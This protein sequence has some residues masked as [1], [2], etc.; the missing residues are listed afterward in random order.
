MVVL[1]IFV[2]MLYHHQPTRFSGSNPHGR[3]SDWLHDHNSSHI[4]IIPLNQIC[5]DVSDLRVS[6][7]NCV[8]HSSLEIVAQHNDCQDDDEIF[9]YD[10]IFCYFF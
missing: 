8:L 7:D 5:T 9:I 1:G 10:L 3:L 2:N 4:A 6:L